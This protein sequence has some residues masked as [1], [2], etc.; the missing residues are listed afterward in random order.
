[1]YISIPSQVSHGIG[2]AQDA[3]AYHGCNTVESRV[4]PFGSAS[5]LPIAPFF[6]GF[7]FLLQ[8]RASV[9]IRTA[10]ICIFRTSCLK[11]RVRNAEGMLS[12][13]GEKEKLKPC[14][15]S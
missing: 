5:W 3:S 1:M 8:F 4:P 13:F 15:L 6:I 9:H 2:E 11:F 14:F 10:H 12:P 7:N